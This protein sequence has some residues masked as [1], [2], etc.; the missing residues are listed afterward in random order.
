[1]SPQPQKPPVN[2]LRPKQT[3]AVGSGPGQVIGTCGQNGG[4]WG[5]SGMKGKQWGGGLPAPRPLAHPHKDTFMMREMTGS[6]KS[7]QLCV[8]PVTEHGDAKFTVGS[9]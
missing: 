2:W 4:H 7:A 8:Q 9:S 1:M 5:P 3:E 6:G